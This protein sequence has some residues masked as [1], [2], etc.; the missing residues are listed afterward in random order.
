MLLGSA[1]FA[2]VVPQGV[3]LQNRRNELFGFLHEL[4]RTLNACQPASLRV[5][6]LPLVFPLCPYCLLSSF[7]LL[8]RPPPFSF[9]HGNGLNR[10]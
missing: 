2:V 1:C 6:R 4:V 8:S 9:K 7:L 5:L 10:I 3:V